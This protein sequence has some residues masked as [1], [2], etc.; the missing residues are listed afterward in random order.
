MSTSFNSKYVSVITTAK[1]PSAAPMKTVSPNGFST[2]LG[3][4]Q[5]WTN[6][7]A[8]NISVMSRTEHTTAFNFDMNIF[9]FLAL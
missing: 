3:Y 5:F 1:I 4:T 7:Y 2:V 9:Y 6:M 8:V